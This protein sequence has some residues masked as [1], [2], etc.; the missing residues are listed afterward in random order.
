MA[1]STIIVYFYGGYKSKIRAAGFLLWA[2][3]GKY[4]TGKGICYQDVHVKITHN[5]AEVWTARD[6]LVYLET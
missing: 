5:V 4:I 3:D 2:P 1:A 6:N